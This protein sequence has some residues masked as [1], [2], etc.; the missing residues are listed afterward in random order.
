[1]VKLKQPLATVKTS[2]VKTESPA[3]ALN[4]AWANFPMP[5][6]FMSEDLGSLPQGM[7]WLNS[8]D[9]AVSP[10]F[11]D[12]HYPTPHHLKALGMRGPQVQTPIPTDVM[13]EDLGS[14]PHGIKWLDSADLELN[15]A[16]CPLSA[17]LPDACH[18]D[19]AVMSSLLTA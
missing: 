13:S 3:A 9:L 14:L 4:A 19:L 12:T 17:N 15:S 6:D 10:L 16:I 8:A 11:S 7:D 1:M 5:G 2:S 18:R